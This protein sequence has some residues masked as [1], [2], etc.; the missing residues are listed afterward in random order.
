MAALQ[1]RTSYFPGLGWM[2]QH[3]LW[4]EIGP[5]WPKQSWDHWMRLN[6]TAKG[7]LPS[8]AYCTAPRALKSHRVGPPRHAF[9]PTSSQHGSSVQ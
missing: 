1:M 8:N 7:G 2:M 6:T 5:H 3:N 9:Q 4:L